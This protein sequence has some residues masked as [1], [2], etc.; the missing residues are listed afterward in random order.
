LRWSARFMLVGVLICSVGF[1]PIYVN[2]VT[3]ETLQ[4]MASFLA[5][6]VFVFLIGL[7]LRRL[8]KTFR[9]T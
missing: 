5:I 4:G 3:L 9:S 2:G 1:L 6:G 7:L 8:A